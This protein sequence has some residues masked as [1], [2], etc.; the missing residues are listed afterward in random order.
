MKTIRTKGDI[1]VENI[2]IGDILYEYEYGCE[3][4][5]T[6]QTLP[7]ES[8]KQKGFWI[9]KGITDNGDI[10]NYGVSEEYPHYAPNLYN[11]RAYKT[12]KK[13]RI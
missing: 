5:T 8:K 7:V 12:F 2:K 1:C 11:Y 9:W 4:K 10:I 3:I 13:N 6:V